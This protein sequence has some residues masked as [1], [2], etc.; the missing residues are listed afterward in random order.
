MS[1]F[2]I[3][4]NANED[5]DLIED[6]ALYSG[7]SR[8]RIAFNRAITRT[9]MHMRSLVSQEIRDYY[10]IKKQEIDRDIRIRF[11]KTGA[12]QTGSLSFSGFKSIGLGRLA[13]TRQG[14]KHVTTKV[15][16]ASRAKIVRPGG[17][18]KILATS[19]GLAAVWKR[20][21]AVL[22]RVEDSDKP[23]VLYA[24]TF[25]RFFERPNVEKALNIEME[26][27]FLKRLQHEAKGLFGDDQW[28]LSDFGENPGSY[29]R[30]R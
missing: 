6:F 29:R 21:R 11:P 14:K 26:E 5:T 2:D 4:I 15:L 13:A 1:L 12:Y 19:K 8:V 18:R 30:K 17:S 27:Y 9:L 28:G 3:T 23:V 20:G 10:A 25:M 24:P 22:A 7:S 16:K